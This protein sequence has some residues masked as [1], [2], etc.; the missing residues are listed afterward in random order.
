MILNSTGIAAGWRT[1]WM[2]EPRVLI[3]NGMR[4]GT[5]GYDNS[6]NRNGNS[7]GGNPTSTPLLYDLATLVGSRFSRAGLP[8]SNIPRRYHSTA[9]ML[10]SGAVMI[11]GSNPNDDVSTYTFVTPNSRSVA[12]PIFT[13][14]YSMDFGFITHSVHMD[15]KLVSVLQGSQQTCSGPPSNTVYSPGPGWIIFM[16]GGVPSEVQQVMIGSGANPPED[17]AA[18]AVL[19][20][21]NGPLRIPM[22]LCG[23]YL[24]TINS[25][26]IAHGQIV[27]FLDIHKYQLVFSGVIKRSG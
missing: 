5:A 14:L 16:A 1:E 19:E 22:L 13:S 10:P 11:G 2:L 8:T 21:S 4:T 18:I 27:D 17:D 20:L 7:N 23:L 6:Q 25:I 12:R 24:L 3:L 15:Q 26:D 9:T